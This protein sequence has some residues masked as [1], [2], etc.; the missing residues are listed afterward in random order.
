MQHVCEAGSLEDDMVDGDLGDGMRVRAAPS[1]TRK[2]SQ[3]STGPTVSLLPDAE[4]L[5]HNSLTGE[6]P[7]TPSL[8]TA[9]WQPSTCWKL[10]RT[11]NVLELIL[12]Q[13]TQI[14][15]HDSIKSKPTLHTGCSKNE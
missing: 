13:Q 5:R 12:K 8:K 4:L 15:R 6:V 1:F 10:Q 14:L 7:W 11:G 2:K 3:S 9:G